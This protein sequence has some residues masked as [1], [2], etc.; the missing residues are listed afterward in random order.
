MHWWRMK[1]FLNFKRPSLNT[2]WTEFC[3]LKEKGHISG[4]NC[5]KGKKITIIIIFC[6]T[7]NLSIENNKRFC[8]VIEIVKKLWGDLLKNKCNY[9]RTERNK[10]LWCEDYSVKWGNLRSFWITN[11]GR[12]YVR[13]GS[14]TD[15]T[16]RQSPV[17]CCS[18]RCVRHTGNGCRYTARSSARRGTYRGTPPPHDTRRRLKG[19]HKKTE[20]KS[21]QQPN[22]RS[23]IHAHM[24][25]GDP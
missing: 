14:D 8:W 23:P 2:E 15:R 19:T 3:K 1:Q 10:K 9:I 22:T 12:T 25:H 4:A 5:Y 18:S 7:C 17:R 20:S 21:I 13:V 6:S 11:R 16:S 24:L